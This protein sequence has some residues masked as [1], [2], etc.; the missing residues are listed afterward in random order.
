MKTNY[1]IANPFG[2]MSIKALENF[3]Q[4]IQYRLPEDYRHYLL[5]FNGAEPI[6]TVCNISDDEGTT[7]VHGMLG[8]H[9]GSEHLQLESNFGDNNS[10][11]KTGLLAFA[12][13]QAGNDFCICLLPK[14]YG[15]VYFYDHESSCADD[16]DTLIKLA[17]SFDCFIKSLISEEEYE[18]SLADTDSEFFARLQDARNNPQI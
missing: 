12:Y 9:N 8:I 16:I 1:Q 17:D 2:E 18:S 10:T 15:E 13:D 7:R 14:H 6:N 11:K 3:E 4:E 5:S